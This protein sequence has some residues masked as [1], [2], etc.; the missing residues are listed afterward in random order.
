MSDRLC[1]TDSDAELS[2]TY[3]T[4]RLGRIISYSNSRVGHGLCSGPAVRWW[5]NDKGNR[6]HRGDLQIWL[7]HFILHLN[8]PPKQD[9]LWLCL[10]DWP[11]SIALCIHTHVVWQQMKLHVRGWLL[12]AWQAVR[13]ALDNKPDFSTI[14]NLF[15]VQINLYIEFICHIWF[16]RI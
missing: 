4:V 11:C 3:T 13:T 6:E 8:E 1:T 7:T 5:P 12:V 14:Q 10:P 2:E 9:S 16:K 15:I